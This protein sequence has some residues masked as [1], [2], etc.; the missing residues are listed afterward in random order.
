MAMAYQNFASLGVNLNRQK[1]GPLDISNVFTSEAD[2]KY[3][4]T[5]GTFTNG[6]SEY[7]YKNANEKIVPYPYEG[8]VLATVIGGVVNVY[9]LALAADGN[10]ITQKI[11]S[12]ADWEATEGVAEIL[13]KPNMRSGVDLSGNIDNTTIILAGNGKSQA[14]VQNGIAVGPGS[15]AGGLAFLVKEVG[16]YEKKEDGTDS[17]APKT[18]QNEL[19]NAFKLI[20][21]A[22]VTNGLITINTILKGDN[23]GDSWSGNGRKVTFEAF[24]L[25]N[26]IISTKE[27]FSFQTTRWS[28]TYTTVEKVVINGTEVIIVFNSSYQLN[29]TDA[30]LIQSGGLSSSGWCCWFPKRPTY[31][32]VRITDIEGERSDPKDLTCIALGVSAQARVTGAIAIGRDVLADGPYSMALTKGATAKGQYAIAASESA[33]A[34]GEYAVAIGQSASASATGAIAL[35]RRTSAQGNGAVALGQSTSA[36]GSGSLAFGY[37]SIANSAYSVAGGIQSQAAYCSFAFGDQAKTT[38]SHSFAFGN[39]AQAWSAYSF[40]FGKSAIAQKEGSFAFG[41]NTKAQAANSIVFGAQAI[42]S[43]VCSFAFGDVYSFEFSQSVN[44]ILT[45][46]IGTGSFAMGRGVVADGYRSFAFGQSF[47]DEENYIFEPT[48]TYGNYAFAFGEGTSADGNYSFAFGQGTRA[49]N[50]YEVAFGKYNR[51]QMSNTLFSIGN[52][53]SD[54]NRSNLFQINQDGT[55]YIM[56]LTTNKLVSLQSLL[57]LSTT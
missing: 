50:S 20:T 40:A 52:G 17:F 19:I 49:H 3:Y 21:T 4:L 9:T 39:G 25:T 23:A 6:V 57:N 42:A 53:T 12:Q 26:D 44:E 46:A 33:V 32:T 30:K 37:N 51:S 36:I 22:D 47:A 8:Q 41:D 45:Q 18:A 56:N 1:Y 5:K 28:P 27:P 31:G 55:V 35:G 43:G 10:F 14:Y 48:Q 15:V 54:T 11:A 13:N 38:G 7:W 24:T 29:S 16:W 2:L 34:N